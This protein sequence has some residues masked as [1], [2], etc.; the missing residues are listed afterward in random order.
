MIDTEGGLIVVDSER[1]LVATQAERWL[2]FAMAVWGGIWFLRSAMSAGSRAG[3]SGTVE[4]GSDGCGQSRIE[5]AD[6]ARERIPAV[7]RYI[8]AGVS[9][10]TACALLANVVPPTVAYAILCLALAARCVIDQIAEERATRRRSAVLGRSRRVDRVLLI[11]MALAAVSTLFLIPLILAQA[12]R[13]AAIVVTGCA[14]AMVAVA[15]RI[16]TAPPLLLGDDLEAEQIVDRETRAT[17]T[18][19]ACFFAVATSAVFL[20]FNGSAVAPAFLLL[21]FGLAAWML[22]YARRLGRTPLV[23]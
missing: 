16:A 3:S 21:G 15:W 2:F 12:D 1:L 14:A 9:F 22:L 17:R 18:G 10:G 19:M 5:R 8:L 23:S 11:W 13:V 6:N 20:G 7:P 4:P